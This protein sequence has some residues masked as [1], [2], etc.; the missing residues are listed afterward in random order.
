MGKSELLFGNDSKKLKEMLDFIHLKTLCQD[1]CVLPPV[2][3]YIK[4]LQRK[5]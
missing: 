1:V 3:F 5:E 4:E 2:R